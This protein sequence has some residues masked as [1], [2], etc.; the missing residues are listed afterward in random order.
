M[1][2]AATPEELQDAWN[3]LHMHNMADFMIF[4]LGMAARTNPDAVK[5]ALQD[6]FS[7]GAVAHTYRRAASEAHESLQVA[8][9]AAVLLGEVRKQLEDVEK[10]LDVIEARQQ[11]L[12][13]ERVA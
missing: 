7:P 4:A 13:S 9:Q 8:R 11:K 1:N 3:H 12:L 6:V 10:R 5:A 2:H